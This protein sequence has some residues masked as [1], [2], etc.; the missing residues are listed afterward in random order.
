[1]D[2]KIFELFEKTR[3][4]MHY[5]GERVKQVDNSLKTYFLEFAETLDLIENRPF[6]LLDIT[7]NDF[8]YISPKYLRMLGYKPGTVLDYNFFFDAV[9]PDDFP[10]TLETPE[11]FLEFIKQNKVTNG[12]EYKLISDF[13]LK[14]PDGIYI[15]V[16]EQLIV[17][18][19]SRDNFPWLF[20]SICDIAPIQEIE[21]PS[22]GII[23]NTSSGK[24]EKKYRNIT[25]L[26]PQSRLTE[27]E[28]E[29]L[30]LISNGYASKQIAAKLN[31]SINTVNNH[32]KNILFKTGCSNTFEAIKFN[33]N[34]GF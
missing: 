23:I 8:V 1:M 34:F 27:R 33:G 19:F 9:H 21:S 5:Y 6:Y 14:M 12:K 22:G 25:R 13:R 10:T 4:Q 18:K 30:K 11:M 15:R 16:L 29:I 2:N 32:R 26:L 3:R 7:Q 20:L 28:F 24:I 17:L 31:I